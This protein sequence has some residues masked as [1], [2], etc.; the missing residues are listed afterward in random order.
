ML[1]VCSRILSWYSLPFLA[2]LL[3]IG[4]AAI[5]PTTP[6]SPGDS[7]TAYKQ[8]IASL[9]NIK[10]FKL[11]GR[12]GVQSEGKGF[13][14]ATHWQHDDTSDNI[15]LFSPLG[16]QIATI[17]TT[18]DSVELIAS[19]GKSFNAKDAETL[20]QLTLGWSLPMKGL[21]D[22]VLGRPASGA[23]AGDAIWDSAGRLTKLK[24]DGWE[25]EYPEYVEASGQQLPGKINLR[26]P[27]LY[28]KLVVEQWN[29]S[30]QWE[31]PPSDQADQP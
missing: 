1:P 24:Q 11:R 6:P 16:G 15:V 9:A 28:L 7:A 18:V 31:I 12:I 19:D 13:S 22:W 2:G 4:C 20:T 17:K 29:I 10:Q 30:G 21:S 5:Q 3:L 25:I 8:H 27:K 23:D 26:N 14:G